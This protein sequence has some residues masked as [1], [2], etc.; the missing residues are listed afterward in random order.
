MDFTPIS[1]PDNSHRN[2]QR[3][4][5]NT[6][7]HTMLEGSNNFQLGN[8]RRWFARFAW[9]IA[10]IALVIISWKASSFLRSIEG[11]Y[12]G[13]VLDGLSSDSA[14]VMTQG[15]AYIR[16]PQGDLV[17]YGHYFETNG[18]WFIH[19]FRISDHSFDTANPWLIKRHIGAFI[20]ISPPNSGVQYHFSKLP[21]LRLW[22]TITTGDWQRAE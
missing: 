20:I 14:L 13:N 10:G 22:N 3:G 19:L 17:L 18:N 12:S 11:E 15:N 5:L 6:S 2:I 16:G 21:G 4:S 8:S 9:L 1:L 7:F